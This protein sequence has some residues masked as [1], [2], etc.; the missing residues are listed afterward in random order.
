MKCWL[1]ENP[2][3]LPVLDSWCCEPWQTLAW[4][5]IHRGPCPTPRYKSDNL[6]IMH[7]HIC[8]IYECFTTLNANSALLV[9]SRTD[10]LPSLFL[11]SAR[12]IS[13]FLANFSKSAFVICGV[14]ILLI[15]CTA[16]FHTTLNA[17]ID[18]PINS[19]WANQR[20]YLPFLKSQ[21]PCTIS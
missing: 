7:H 10:T 3:L 8:N 2:F 14:E 11:S 20:T 18:A 12:N 4:K 6:L 21:R 13:E 15:F 17:P 9:T 5:W 16:T 1:S 19:T